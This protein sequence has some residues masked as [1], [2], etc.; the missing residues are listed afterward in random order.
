MQMMPSEWNWLPPGTEMVGRTWIGGDGVE[1]QYVMQGA[2]GAWPYFQRILPQLN[3]ANYCLIWTGP[4]EQPV[5]TAHQRKQLTNFTCKLAEIMADHDRRLVAP[6]LSVGWPRFED[7]WMFDA[8]AETLIDYDGW[9]SVHEYSAPRMQDGVG[10]YCLR[11]RELVKRMGVTPRMMITE[12]GIDGGVIG[13]PRKG[14]QHYTTRTDFIEQLSWYAGE[15]DDY[16][17]MAFPF[18][19]EPEATW[20]SFDCGPISEWLR[21]AWQADATLGQRISDEMQ[22]HIIPANP[23]AAFDKYAAKYGWYP[24]SREVDT[25]SAPGYRAN[26]NLR[27]WGEAAPFVCQDRALGRDRAL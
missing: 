23:D 5:D 25:S 10:Y 20:T 22:R 17:D 9:F 7:M 27:G 26:Q 21:K 8:I 14:W 24:R 1:A 15:L 4:N 3:K 13:E 6:N 19:W 12:C 16:V 2:A 11:Y 18:I